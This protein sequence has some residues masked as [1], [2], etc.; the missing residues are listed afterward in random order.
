MWGKALFPIHLVT[1]KLSQ[2]V[3][4]CT[5]S[6]KWLQCWSGWLGPTS[7][8]TGGSHSSAQA[9][10]HLRG[11]KG[12]HTLAMPLLVGTS[13]APTLS[14]GR[15]S[16]W[17]QPQCRWTQVCGNNDGHIHFS[18]LMTSGEVLIKTDLYTLQKLHHHQHQHHHYCH[19]CY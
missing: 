3:H 5:L 17:S 16:P 14:P 9:G 7:C 6:G 12:W 13:L 11:W 19:H 2:T 15:C 10:L 4:C 8:Q 1:G 18:D